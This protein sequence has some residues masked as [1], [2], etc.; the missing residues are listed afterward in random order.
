MLARTAWLPCQPLPSH[1]ARLE[2]W[3]PAGGSSAPPPPW[4]LMDGRTKLDASAE[5]AQSL[6][7]RVKAHD[8]QTRTSLSAAQI[9]S[10]LQS[11]QIL[12]PG[13]GAR[14]VRVQN[15]VLARLVEDI[16]H[17]PQ[18]MVRQASVL[19]DLQRCGCNGSSAC[20]TRPHDR[21]RLIRITDRP[22][23]HPTW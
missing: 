3:V 16:E 17:V 1:R 9:A 5:W 11:L 20:V 7:A 15:G 21:C 13:L 18:R 10:R 4:R 19:P 12:L 8:L 23:R 22:C 14:L 6:A 2:R